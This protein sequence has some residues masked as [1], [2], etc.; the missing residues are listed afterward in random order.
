MVQPCI[1]IANDDRSYLSM[2]KQLLDEEG[3]PEIHCVLG[4]DA[5]PL[6]KREKP[7]LV[8]LDINIGQNDAGWRLLDFVRL[9]PETAG[10]P[11]IICSTD[12]RLPREKAY[13]LQTQRCYF[14][15]KPFQINDL[16]RMLEELIGPPPQQLLERE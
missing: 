4:P 3:Y 1:V 7:D 2:I 5:Y 8:L 11:V 16:L 9:D 12:P 10:I 14:L 6:I 13:W 15:E